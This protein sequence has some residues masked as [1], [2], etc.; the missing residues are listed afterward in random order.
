MR[1][2]IAGSRTFKDYELLSACCDKA[3]I[4]QANIEII[5][6]AADGADTLGKNYAIVKNY[7]LIEFPADW[8]RFDKR[9]G[10]LRNKEMA[11]YSDALIAF[12]DGKSK[13]T[14]HM[15]DLANKYNLKVKIINF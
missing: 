8:E 3:L 4:R 6:G 15:I 14:K 7:P 12:W 10:Y 5:S 11:K 13:G 1:V 2:I 9:A